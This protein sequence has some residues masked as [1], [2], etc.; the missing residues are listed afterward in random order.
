M[1]C[2]QSEEEDFAGRLSH[3]IEKLPAANVSALRVLMK[4]LHKVFFFVKCH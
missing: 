4:L 2:A 3:L 1:E